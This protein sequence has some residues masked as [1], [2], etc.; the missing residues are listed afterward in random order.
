MIFSLE[1]ANLTSQANY[2]RPFARIFPTFGAA[3]CTMQ[4]TE[5]AAK[6]TRC[7]LIPVEVKVILCNPESQ[8][9]SDFRSCCGKYGNCVRLLSVIPSVGLKLFFPSL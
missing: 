6:N 2:V 4:F 5:I 1:L 3:M 9:G 7:N 8:I